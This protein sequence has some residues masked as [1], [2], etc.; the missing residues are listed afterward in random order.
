MPRAIASHEQLSS[1]DSGTVSSLDVGDLR[2]KS[3]G[4]VRKAAAPKRVAEF[5]EATQDYV[6]T[7]SNRIY[8]REHEWEM[9]M[10]PRYWAAFGLA[11]LLC[12]VLAFIC[13]AKYFSGS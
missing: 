2:I 12:A 3:A 11:L 8:G 9:S 4:R 13:G 7:M 6:I 1:A 10:L 5:R